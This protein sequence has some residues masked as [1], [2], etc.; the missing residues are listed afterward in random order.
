M[1]L[2]NTSLPGDCIFVIT[3]YA[4]LLF[5]SHIKM[6]SACQKAKIHFIPIME[7]ER[8]KLIRSFGKTNFGRAG[9]PQ[10]NGVQDL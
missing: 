1:F 9:Y 6:P 3:S 7:L 8:H 5:P 4:S 10:K 2:M